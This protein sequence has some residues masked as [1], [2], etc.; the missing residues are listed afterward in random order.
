[1]NDFRIELVMEYCRME[2]DSLY[3]LYMKTLQQKN[4]MEWRYYKKGQSNFNRISKT[5][6][7]NMD[8]ELLDIDWQ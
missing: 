2:Q 6:E 8:D 5:R 3:V 7:I 4:P 1:M